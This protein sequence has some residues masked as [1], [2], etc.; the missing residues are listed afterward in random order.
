[1]Q[2]AISPGERLAASHGAFW[3]TEGVTRTNTN[4]IQALKL[5]VFAS[6]SKNLQ[7]V[8]AINKMLR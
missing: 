3:C 4:E 5:L 1:M 2:T 6:L 8:A 7:H